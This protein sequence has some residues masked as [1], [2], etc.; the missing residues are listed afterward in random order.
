MR[1]GL[2]VMVGG[3]RMTMEETNALI[4]QGYEERLKRIMEGSGLE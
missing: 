3:E 2:L 1:D 4:R